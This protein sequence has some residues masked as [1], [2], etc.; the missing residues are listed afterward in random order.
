MAKQSII[1]RQL[2]REKFIEKY[3]KKRR[4][5][6]KEFS[7]TKDF[8]IKISIHKKIEKLPRNS[9][10]I[11]SKNRCW[12]TGRGRGFYRDFG[13]CRHMIRE[14]AHNGI[15]PGVYKASW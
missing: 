6:L 15:L 3:K 1:Q 7:I 2:R 9:I 11:R 8:N 10:K 13:L 4:N 14:L 5:L 12:K